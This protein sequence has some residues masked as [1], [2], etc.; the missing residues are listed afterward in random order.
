MACGNGP[1]PV[2]SQ[3]VGPTPIGALQGLDPDHVVY[4]GTASKSLAPALRLAWM[5][6]PDRLIDRVLEIKATGEW[7]SGSLD[8]LTLAEFMSSGAYDRHV[9]G[10]RLRYRRRRDQ[11]VAA[12]AEHAPHV[13]VSGIAAGLHAVLELP[14]GTEQSITR[15]A[16]WQGLAVQGLAQFTDPAGPAVARDALVIPYGRPPEHSFATILDALLRALPPGD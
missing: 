6:V 9:R 15:A 16:L 10:M 11:L 13:H 5:V 8:Q 14:A 7:Q 2:R 12:L 3:G 4:L 1:L